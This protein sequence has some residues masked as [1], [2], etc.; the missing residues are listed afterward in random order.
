[1]SPD[2]DSIPEVDLPVAANGRDHTIEENYA[3]T[4]KRREAY[5]VEKDAR[6]REILDRRAAARER[7]FDAMRKAAFHAGNVGLQYDALTNNFSRAVVTTRGLDV[8][9]ILEDKP[10]APP[11]DVGDP[12][13]ID[14]EF[15]MPTDEAKPASVAPP[16]PVPTPVVPERPPVPEIRYADAHWHRNAAIKS[17]FAW[18]FATLV[19]LFVGFGLLTIVGLPY[20][21]PTE[22]VN[23]YAML[24]VGVAAIFGMKLLFDTLWF[25]VGRRRELGQL[26]WPMVTGVS[27]LTSLLLGVE[28]AL[29]GQAIVVYSIKSS[30]EGKGALPFWQGMLIA[31]AISTATLLFSASLGYQK[32]ARSVTRED[33]LRARYDEDM[34]EYRRQ[35]Q[36]IEEEQ[37]RADQ[38]KHRALEEERERIRR[39]AQRAEELETKRHDLDKKKLDYRAELAERAKDNYAQ[40]EAEGPEA[41]EP[42]KTFQNLP[43][44]RAMLQWISTVTACRAEIEFCERELEHEN[45]STLFRNTA[46][47]L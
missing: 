45:R 38:D 12:D 37:A 18:F 3:R 30:F 6:R 21:R 4:L 15:T 32:G 41:T 22:R 29:G 33:L 23:L 27:L 47:M 14:A 17:G 24:G 34:A 13:V 46:N 1:M 36:R 35:V 5:A 11:S 44:F 42:F 20:M 40:A 8:E 43:D 25:E 10:D 28:A 16:P 26:R 2:Y 9:N 7:M 39:I 19:G 31:A